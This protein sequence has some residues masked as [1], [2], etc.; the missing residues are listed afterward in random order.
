MR[1]AAVALRNRMV[2]MG[3][4]ARMLERSGRVPTRD[5]NETAKQRDRLPYLAAAC[6][7]SDASDAQDWGAR[8]VS[9][10]LLLLLRFAVTSDARDQSAVLAL[11]DEIDARG[12]HWRPSA[13][14]FFRRTSNEVCRAIITFDDPKRTTILKRH[15]ARIDNP[16]LKRAFRAAVNID[17]RT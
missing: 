2:A 6:A 11:A 9:E 10:W 3:S 15:L 12:L 7:L 16:A 8:Q 14:T 5:G 1:T 4:E 17:E 13:P